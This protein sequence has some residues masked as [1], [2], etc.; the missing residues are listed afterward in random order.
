M[1]VRSY[2]CPSVGQFK[3]STISLTAHYNQMDKL[4]SPHLQS[5]IWFSLEEKIVGDQ[6]Q[7]FITIDLVN[8]IE[9]LTGSHEEIFDWTAKCCQVVYASL[10]RQEDSTPVCTRRRTCKANKRKMLE[11]RTVLLAFSLKSP[12]QPYQTA[13][14]DGPMR[15]PY[16]TV[17]SD[18]PIRRPYE[19]VQ[20][21]GLV[22]R[23]EQPLRPVCTQPELSFCTQQ[24]DFLS[25]SLALWI[26]ATICLS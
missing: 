4:Q 13:L 1:P 12:R 19:T 15:R 18:G 2:Y 3:T 22:I 23:T 17:Q 6:P 24:P 7:V 8:A 25:R 26:S 5:I 21:G 14:S 10:W 20:S 9:K 11:P 16:E